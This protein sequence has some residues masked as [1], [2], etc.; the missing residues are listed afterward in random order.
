[1]SNEILR[2]DR[3]SRVSHPLVSAGERNGEVTHTGGVRKGRDRD[4]SS[5]AGSLCSRQRRH[6]KGVE[7]RD[8]R[9]TRRGRSGRCRHVDRGGAL[10][11]TEHEVMV[12]RFIYS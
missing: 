8:R 4:R 10:T 7:R 9:W 6:L 5:L 1:M 11:E 2:E 12:T 3:D